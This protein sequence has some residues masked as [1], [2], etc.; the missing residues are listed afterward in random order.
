MRA[1]AGGD[2]LALHE[3]YERTHRIVFTLAVRLTRDPETAAELTVDVYHEVWRRASTYDPEVGPVVAWLM[4]V[5]RSRTIDRLRHDGRKKRVRP[6]HEDPLPVEPPRGP[7]EVLERREDSAL[8]RDALTR[9]TPFEREAI[10]VAFFSEL[11]YAETATRLDQ[12][13]GT[14][15]TRIR[16]GLSKLRHD[17]TGKVAP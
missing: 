3:L 5:A 1:I 10:E 15:K 17:L 2:Q 9:L 11:T 14:I 7:D 6:A 4:T 12:P 16:S 8:L 13:V